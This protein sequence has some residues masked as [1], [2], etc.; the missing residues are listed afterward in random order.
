[1]CNH[2]VFSGATF[3]LLNL[4]SIRGPGRRSTCVVPK[5]DNPDV[6][7]T[8]RD[9]GPQVQ[10]LLTIALNTRGLPTSN[11]VARGKRSFARDHAFLPY[12]GGAR[13][14]ASGRPPPAGVD[15]AGR[16]RLAPPRKARAEVFA[17]RPAPPFNPY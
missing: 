17:L 5:F 9:G 6:G 14:A 1:L 10:F 4:M 2:A 11:R 7:R 8:V 15:A 13:T 16:V 3:I 12:T